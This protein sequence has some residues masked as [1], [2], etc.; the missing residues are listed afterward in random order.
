MM[1]SKTKTIEPCGIDFHFKYLCDKCHNEM[2]LSLHEVRIKNFICVCGS[3]H[4]KFKTRTIGKITLNYLENVQEQ[5]IP[6]KENTSKTTPVKNI[7]R[8]DI[9]SRAVNSLTKFG[10]TKDE[11]GIMVMEAFERIASNDVT[12]LVKNALKSCGERNA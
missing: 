6:T 1:K 3:C 12:I 4:K 2:W 8:S 5:S 11:A 9:K 10:F 7:L